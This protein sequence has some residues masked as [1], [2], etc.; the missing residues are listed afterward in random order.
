VKNKFARIFL[1]RHG[2]VLNKK[3]IIYGYLPVFLSPKGKKQAKKAGIFLKRKNIAAIFVS[4]KKEHSKR[5]KLSK[6]RL[7]K[8]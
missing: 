7:V 3:K 8:E 2:E 5:R 4:P 6:K 1:V